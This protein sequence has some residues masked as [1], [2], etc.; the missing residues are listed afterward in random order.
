MLRSLVG[1]EMCIRDR[2]MSYLEASAELMVGGQGSELYRLNLE[3]GQFFAPI[4]TGLPDI[5]V[6]GLSL[7]HNLIGL[8]GSDGVL[9]CYDP[10]DR[11]RLAR[12]DIGAHANAEVYGG[13]DGAEISAVKFKE[14]GMMIAAGLSTGQCLLFDLRSP[15]PLHVKDHQY[16]ERIT[17]V[18]FHEQTRNM[19]TT[20]TKICKVWGRDSGKMFTSIEP[21]ADINDMAIVPGT[22]MMVMAV[23][24]PRMQVYYVPELGPAPKWCAFLDSLTEELEEEEVPQVYDDY[25]FLTRPELQELGL[26]KLI[27][28]NILRAYMHGFFI[29]SKLYHRA[30]A[31]LTPFNAKEYR[32]KQIKGQVDMERTNRITIEKKL[33]KVN[34]ALAA[35]LY[36]ADAKKKRDSEKKGAG[37]QKD[38]ELHHIDSDDDQEDKPETSKVALLKDSRFKKMFESQEYEINED[39]EVFRHLHPGAA[40]AKDNATAKRNRQL[41]EEH[42]EQVDDSDD[43]DDSAGDHPSMYELK[44]GHEMDG[45][46]PS[47]GS[48]KRAKANS[49]SKKSL[50]ER[51]AGLDRRGRHQ[52]NRPLAEGTTFTVDMSAVK[53]KGKGKGK[54]HSTGGKG[55]GKGG[56]KGKGKGGKGKSW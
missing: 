10:R 36:E 28:S 23:E 9:E 50:Q 34:A 13:A 21:K 54:G 11:R 14:D 1:S 5:N 55:K 24:E 40:A 8:G 2:D 45:I 49:G 6:V 44:D 20:D 16:G 42:F 35:K 22:G 47:A 38:A 33:P 7:G 26:D 3:Q 29:D 37:K 25:K 43:D 52:G 12:L 18:H 39:S 32:K 51:L 4:H 19:I 27:G 30:K 15:R 17:S 31:V 41:V 46:N 48:S 56:S 53:G